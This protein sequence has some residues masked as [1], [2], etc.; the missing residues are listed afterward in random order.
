MTRCAAATW[1]TS[2]S[3]DDGSSPASTCSNSSASPP[4]RPDCQ[5]QTACP[6]LARPGC[7]PDEGSSG[8]R[9]ARAPRRSCPGSLSANTRM[10]PTSVRGRICPDVD[11]RAYPISAG[12]SRR[13]ER[14]QVV[15]ANV[16]WSQ[17]HHSDCTRNGGTRS[18]W[19]HRLFNTFFEQSPPAGSG[20]RG[21]PGRVSENRSIYNTESTRRER[22]LAKTSTSTSQAR[23]G[24]GMARVWPDQQKNWAVW[25]GTLRLVRLCAP[26]HGT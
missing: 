26:G 20:D 22:T 25:A 12:Q 1:P 13:L 2:R 3:A 4:S 24:A 15:L 17:R 7:H 11:T 18:C 8:T 9:Q 16:A 5:Y 19:A 23:C 6:G 10:Q 14:E 21:L